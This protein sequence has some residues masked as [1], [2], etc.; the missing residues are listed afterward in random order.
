[1]NES[2]ITALVTMGPTGLFPAALNILGKMLSKSPMDN[3]CIPL[4]LSLIGAAAG[5][6]I[7]KASNLNVPYPEMMGVLIGFY[8]GAGATGQNQIV[9]Q[10]FPQKP[11]PGELGDGPRPPT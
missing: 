10:L 11:D 2:N 8:L 9:R 7:L 6:F 1:M 4:I 3:R 5:P